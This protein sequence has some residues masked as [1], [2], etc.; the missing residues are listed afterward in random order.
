MS[1]LDDLQRAAHRATPYSAQVPRSLQLR[2]DVHSTELTQ[3]LRKHNV[4]TGALL[5]AHDPGGRRQSAP[6]NQKA[7]ALLRARIEALQLPFFPGQRKPEHCEQPQD[8]FLVLGITGGQ[9]EA[10]MV[11]FEQDALLWTPACG[12]P[13]LM[14]HPAARRITTASDLRRVATARAKPTAPG[15]GR[16]ALAK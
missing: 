7:S 14:L 12:T 16:A 2:V 9:A 13:V 1:P 10:L 3:L 5:T 15:R 6:R 8:G 11:E 4:R